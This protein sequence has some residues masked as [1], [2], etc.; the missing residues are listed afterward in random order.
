MQFDAL[1]RSHAVPNI[2]A[3]VNHADESDWRDLWET[4]AGTFYVDSGKRYVTMA[5]ISEGRIVNRR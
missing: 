1:N 4:V 2:L 5:H 3:F